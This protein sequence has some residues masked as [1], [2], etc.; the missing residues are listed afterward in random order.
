[1]KASTIIFGL[2]VF[3]ATQLFS[4]QSGNQLSWVKD[5]G[6]IQVDGGKLFYE[7]AGKGENIVLLHDGMV[8]R[9]IWDEQF[10]VL[11]KNYRVVRYDRRTYGKSSDPQAP[12]S[13]IEDLIQLF[14]QLNIDRATVFGMSSGGGLAIDFTLKYP[15]KVSAL[16]LVG[17][18]VSGYG[19]S[20]HM[21]NRGGHLKSP[22]ELADPQKAIKYF[23]WDDPYEIYSENVKAKEKVEKLLKANLHPSE[24][25]YLKPAER[26]GAKFLSEIKVPALVL[27]GENDIADVHAHAGVIEY[28]IKNAKREVILNSG[29]LIP[30]EQPEAFNASVGRFLKRAQFFSALFSQGVDAAIQY[31]NELQKSEPN[32]RIF[33]ESEMNA[34]GYRFLQG[35]KIKDAIKIFKINTIAFPNSSN[36]FDSMGEAYLKDG[37]TDLAISNYKKSLELDP[38]NENAKTALKGIKEAGSQKS[39]KPGTEGKNLLQKP[40]SILFDEAETSISNCDGITVD[41]YGRCYVTSWPTKSIYRFVTKDT[42]V[43]VSTRCC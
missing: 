11:A 22:A 35:D 12:Y 42:Q 25:N 14:I 20:P 16:V 24:G 19:Y 8:D 10:P 40:E 36:V 18:V 2:F 33:E 21:T 34:L 6:Y 28:G 13:D 15:E 17:A 31:F 7:M 41:R 4:Q 1:M 5:T 37:Q 9:E 38:K 30:L 23:V 29:H 32:T 39:K 43:C 27:V 3:T 26:P